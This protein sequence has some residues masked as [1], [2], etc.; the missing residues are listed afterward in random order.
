MIRQVGM[1]FVAM[2]STLNV[3]MSFWRWG[4]MPRAQLYALLKLRQREMLAKRWFKEEATK[5]GRRAKLGIFFM[6]VECLGL[7]QI[8]Q[9]SYHPPPSFA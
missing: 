7:P 3:Q 2:F 8:Y 9:F 1:N 5:R 4:A 6:C